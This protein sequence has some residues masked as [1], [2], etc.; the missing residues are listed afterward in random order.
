VFVGSVVV[1][2]HLGVWPKFLLVVGISLPVTLAI[3][4]LV[5]RRWPLTRL[6]FG[7][8]PLHE[9]STAGPATGSTPPAA[10]VA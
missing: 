6:V 5:V 7:L 3:Y 4:E 9:R 8:K 1:H 2:L 10:A